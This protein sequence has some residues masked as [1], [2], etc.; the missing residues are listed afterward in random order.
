MVGLR[1]QLANGLHWLRFELEQSL[2]RAR[3]NLEQYLEAPGDRQQL[4]MALQELR[5]VRGGVGIIECYGAQLLADEMI[6]LLRELLEDRISQADEAFSALSGAALQLFD[7]LDLLG[8]GERDR[9][10]I[11]QPLINELRLARG[12]PVLT[13]G[14]L[15][16]YQL[17]AAEASQTRM[18]DA[19]PASRAVAQATAKRV[20]SAVVPRPRAAGGFAEARGDLRPSVAYRHRSRGPRFL[21]RGFRTGRII[22]TGCHPIA[23]SETLVRSCRY[24]AQGHRR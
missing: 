21:G 24:A 3:S 13:E 11:L 12:K 18:A 10:L 1:P 7:Y 9:A 2:S 16:A 19:T 6:E 20:V 23:R 8:D 17:R 15:L 5:L 4:M 22:A 14:D